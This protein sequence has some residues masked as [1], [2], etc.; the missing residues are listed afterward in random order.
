MDVE[1]SGGENAPNDD[2][3][4]RLL[5]PRDSIE[6]SKRRLLSGRLKQHQLLNKVTVEGAQSLWNLMRQ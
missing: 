4:F 6:N 2:D 5:N 1:L 3:L